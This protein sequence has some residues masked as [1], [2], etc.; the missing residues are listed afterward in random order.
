MAYLSELL[1]GLCES[2]L[3]SGRFRLR[4]PP[5]QH[6][7]C[8]KRGH[9][10][11]SG[12]HTLGMRSLAQQPELLDL[13]RRAAG[14]HA[15]GAP[16]E[17]GSHQRRVSADHQLGS[18]TSAV[19]AS[20]LHNRPTCNTDPT[21]SGRAPTR[22]RMGIAVLRRAQPLR[23]KR[24]ARGAVLDPLTTL[25]FHRRRDYTIGRVKTQKPRAPLSCAGKALTSPTQGY[26]LCDWHRPCP[27]GGHSAN[28]SSP[29]VAT[30]AILP[31]E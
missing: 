23:G 8:E 11:V 12:S 15:D 18:R 26:T 4:P 14:L 28:V 5:R 21:A 31:H 22:K 16:A 7:P 6:D 29:S 9:D 13:T 2:T 30:R 1:C 24:S 17:V 25:A 27:A 20:I 10:A 19:P 3:R